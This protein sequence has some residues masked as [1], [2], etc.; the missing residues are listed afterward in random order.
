MGAYAALLGGR[1]RVL[2]WLGGE[3]DADDEGLEGQNRRRIDRGGRGRSRA[4]PMVAA[5]LAP[6]RLPPPL[7]AQ[8]RLSSALARS[9]KLGASAH[10]RRQRLRAG[11]HDGRRSGDDRGRAARSGCRAEP[12][13]ARARRDRC[14][15]VARSRGSTGEP[16]LAPHAALHAGHVA[17]A[18]RSTE[19]P[20]PVAPFR[21]RPPGV[22]PRAG[23]GPPIGR[24]DVGRD[25][26]RAGRAFQAKSV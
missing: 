21:P 25:A 18:R 26:L 9:A 24:A 10:A 4:R 15:G 19:A 5:G 6:A 8:A 3:P 2:P 1:G 11:S 16:A 17:G 12:Q 14:P 7:G 23:N 22:H 20:G 13:A